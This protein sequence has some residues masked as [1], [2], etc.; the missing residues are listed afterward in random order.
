MFTNYIGKEQIF[1]YLKIKIDSTKIIRKM[2]YA[3]TTYLV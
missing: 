1:K 3:K 2:C